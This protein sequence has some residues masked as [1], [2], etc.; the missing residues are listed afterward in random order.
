MDIKLQQNMTFPNQSLFALHELEEIRAN[1]V[2]PI[3]TRQ[4]WG[5][6]WKQ[7]N[8]DEWHHENY[9]MQSGKSV[10]HG[11]GNPDNTFEANKEQLICKSD[12]GMW[13]LEFRNPSPD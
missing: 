3:S 7:Q 4:A 11:T 8:K 13:T 5:N 2:I 1:K 10:L 6:K 12:T 9:Y